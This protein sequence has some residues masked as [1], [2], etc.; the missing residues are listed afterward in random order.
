MTNGGRTRRLAALLALGGLV[1]I[2]G[3]GFW[4][5]QV[6]VPVALRPDGLLRDSLGLAD[7]D[8]VHLMRLTSSDGRVRLVPDS[9]ELR[10][11]QRVSF[12]TGDG[13]TYLVRFDTLG[14]RAE[15]RAWLD[16]LG[17]LDGPPLLNHDSRWVVHFSGAPTGRYP[18]I[19]EGNL[20]PG[21]GVIVVSG[22]R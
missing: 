20:E 8:A 9:V 1:A 22:R 2:V 14:V 4:Y 5:T 19:V 3:G 18:V 7:G 6:R 13:F 21:R 10:S 11:G 15:Q 17:R 16:R 12:V